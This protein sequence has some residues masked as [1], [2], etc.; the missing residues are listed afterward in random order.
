MTCEDGGMAYGIASHTKATVFVTLSNTN[1]QSHANQIAPQV[2]KS[3]CT[4]FFNLSFYPLNGLEQW[5]IHD[6]IA[7]YFAQI[8]NT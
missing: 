4:E 5:P 6:K 2:M 7:K 3:L 8:I 1:L